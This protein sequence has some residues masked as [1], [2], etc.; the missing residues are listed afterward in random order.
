MLRGPLLGATLA[1]VLTACASSGPPPVKQPRE[2]VMAYDDARTTGTMAFPTV[3]Y[4]SV[5]RFQ[6]P[7]GEY[8]PLR[9]RFQAE[10]A[11][12]AGDHDLRQHVW[13]RP[14]IRSTR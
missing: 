6:L 2:I 12:N 7:D 14:A 9:L 13:R 8:K 11:G 4:E 1:V 5:V 3:N 10:A